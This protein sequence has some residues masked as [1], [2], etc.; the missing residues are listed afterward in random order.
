MFVVGQKVR[1]AHRGEGVV[2]NVDES[3]VHS[4]EVDF[5]SGEWDCYTKDGKEFEDDY[6][7]SL[8]VI[9]E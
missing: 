5:A 9:E 4:V 8:T 1:C 2:V 7:P 3:F 6:E